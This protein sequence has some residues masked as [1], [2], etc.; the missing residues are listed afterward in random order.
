[1]NYIAT[2]GSIHRVLKAEKVLK[3]RGIPFRLIPTPKNLAPYC[4][5]SITF[6]EGVMD[7]VKKAL[8]E[9]GVKV[10]AYYRKEKEGYV[11]V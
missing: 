9:G 3:G 4:D 1:M 10:I 6:E 7:E 8:G 2:F 11:K 5:L